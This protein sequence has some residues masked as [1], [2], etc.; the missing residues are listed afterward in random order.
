MLRKAKRDHKE[1]KGFCLIGLIVILCSFFFF[2]GEPI[3]LGGVLF[4]LLM[5]GALFLG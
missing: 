2:V 1:Y 3:L 4:G 5:N